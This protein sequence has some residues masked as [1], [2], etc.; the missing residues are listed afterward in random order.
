[1][2]IGPITFALLV[3]RLIVPSSIDTMRSCRNLRNIV[4]SLG[5]DL[6]GDL[7][8]DTGREGILVSEVTGI[9]A[10]LSVNARS[11]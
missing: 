6:K 5:G 2:E 10:L 3:S 4:K 1:M 8:T 11:Y 7:L 9:Q